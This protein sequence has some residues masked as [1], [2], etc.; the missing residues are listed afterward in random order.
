[1]AGRSTPNKFGHPFVQH[2][3]LLQTSYRFSAWRWLLD[4]HAPV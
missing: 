3:K 2:T 4:K 1:M